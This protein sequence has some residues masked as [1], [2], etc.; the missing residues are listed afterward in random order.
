MA[1]GAVM[2]MVGVYTATTTRMRKK[3]SAADLIC[4]V[5]LGRRAFKRQKQGMQ[6]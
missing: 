2:V 3:M 4:S 5:T 6:R 1:V